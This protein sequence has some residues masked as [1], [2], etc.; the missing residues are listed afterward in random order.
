MTA[1]TGPD[2]SERT[3]DRTYDVPVP[4][5]CERDDGEPDLATVVKRRAIQ[6]ALSRI[7]GLCGA[8]LTYGVTLVGSPAEATANAFRFPPLHREC[9]SAALDLYPPLG[10]PV[11]GQPAVTHEW[12]LVVT[13]GFELVRPARRSADMRVEFH[14]NAVTETRLL[15]A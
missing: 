13:G 15:T 10:V 4:F 6:C 14:P 8:P 9:A 5:A 12:A 1:R 11:L 7:C 2:L 3:R